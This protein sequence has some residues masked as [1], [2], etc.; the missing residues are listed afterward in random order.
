VSGLEQNFHDVGLLSVGDRLGSVLQ[1]KG[2]RDK[3]AWVDFT[4]TEKRN[5]FGKR[6]AARTDNSDFLHDDGP[7]FDWSGAVKG[8]FKHEGAA[9]FSHLL[10]ENQARGR[11]RSFHDQPVNFP[12]VFQIARVA[13]NL[14]GLDGRLLG[15]L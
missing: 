3:G 1:S 13:A 14:F 15:E 4:R 12:Y 7:G 2:A 6:A 9:R 11:A 8:G 10:G 5:G